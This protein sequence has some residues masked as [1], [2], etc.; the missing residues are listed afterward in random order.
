MIRQQTEPEAMTRS[1]PQVSEAVRTVPASQLLGER[2]LVHIEHQGE[3]YTLR[4]T[5]NNRLILTK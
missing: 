3:R 2:G 5:R 1:N 4:I